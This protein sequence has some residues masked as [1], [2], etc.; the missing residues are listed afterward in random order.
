MI[1][2]PGRKPK[3]SPFKKR[4]LSSDAKIIITL[5]KKQPQTKEEI[6]I[7]TEISDR[8]FYRIIS[9]LEVRQIVKRVDHTYALWNFDFIEKTI[10]TAM[11]KLLGE[12]GYVNSEWLIDEVGKPWQ[13]IQSATLKI[14]KK[15]GLTITTMNSQT[16]FL[17]T[18]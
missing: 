14:A 8:T 3:H 5:I 11:T 18:N 9:L 4:Q 13:E 1:K 15:L 10:E 7:E 6:C 17:K 2:T 16:A 12:N